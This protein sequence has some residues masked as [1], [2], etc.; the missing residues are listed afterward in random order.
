MGEIYDP[1]EGL[2]KPEFDSSDVT[3][4]L[5]RE[6]Q[7]IKDIA[8]WARKHGKGKHAGETIRFPV[9]DGY[10]IYV[11]LSLHPVK[12]IH[13]PYADAY[14][15]EYVHRLTADDIVEKIEQKKALEKIFSQK[16]EE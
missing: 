6:E 2:E 4:S 14:Q 7:Y 12:L 8:E 5:E 3:G 11:V 9:A 1:P 16:K 10:A 13:V 15:F